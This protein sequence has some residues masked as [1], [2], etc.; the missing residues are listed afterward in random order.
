VSKKYE[1]RKERDQEEKRKHNELQKRDKQEK[2]FVLE[3][4]E[5]QMI[6]EYYLLKR[7]TAN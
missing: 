4:H 3:K 6:N 1:I 7:F 5:M 2:K